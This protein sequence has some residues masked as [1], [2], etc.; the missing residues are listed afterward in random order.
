MYI[1][2]KKYDAAKVRLEI[3]KKMA[4][5]GKEAVL[6]PQL[7]TLYDVALEKSGLGLGKG[8]GKVIM[9]EDFFCLLDQIKELPSKFKDNNRNYK[10]AI[11]ALL[12]EMAFD[13][14]DLASY[15][16]HGTVHAAGLTKELCTLIYKTV[17]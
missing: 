17:R 1:I 7:G 11:F 15:Q 9:K 14:E 10:S 6:V 4:A 12:N 2:P 5:D 8:L 3:K 16:F 13:S